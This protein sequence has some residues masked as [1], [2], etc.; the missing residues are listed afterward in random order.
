MA[1]VEVVRGQLTQE[2]ADEENRLVR[3]AV[4]QLFR[5]AGNFKVFEKAQGPPDV[6]DF[7]AAALAEDFDLLRR[8]TEVPQ[9]PP[10]ALH[11]ET[12]VK[13]LQA[14]RVAEPAEI[15][16]APRLHEM[17]RLRENLDQLAGP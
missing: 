13:L 8:E 1:F 12:I 5:A 14:R 7:T 3:D 16:L 17:Y 4:S 11:L 9:R 15:K 10:F 6:G 2:V